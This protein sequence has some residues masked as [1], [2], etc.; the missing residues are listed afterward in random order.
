LLK[1]LFSLSLLNKI[2]D[3]IEEKFFSP[4]DAVCL[5]NSKDLG[6]YLL[7]SGKIEV[8]ES[9][10]DTILGVLTKGNHFGEVTFFTGLDRSFTARSMD[11]SSV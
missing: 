6:F 1:K 11:F 9:R 4:E 3:L 2:T 7:M 5:E 10:T 8:F